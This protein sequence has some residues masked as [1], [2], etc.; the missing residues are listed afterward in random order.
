MTLSPMSVVLAPMRT[1][2]YINDP[3]TNPQHE[4][5]PLAPMDSPS[6]PRRNAACAPS[7]SESRKVA[8]PVVVN[9]LTGAR[10]RYDG[11]GQE[12]LE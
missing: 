9:P 12:V 1:V 3:D 10:K 4:Y 8:V 7:V 5:Y 6:P 2:P 11:P